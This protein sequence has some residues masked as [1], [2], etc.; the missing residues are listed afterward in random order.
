MARLEFQRLCRPL[1]REAESREIEE[2][3]VK[4][5]AK[6]ADFHD[7]TGLDLEILS[8]DQ[9]TTKSMYRNASASYEIKTGARKEERNRG[10]VWFGEDDIDAR[11][12]RRREDE[13][14]ELA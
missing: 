13:S 8:A 4:R 11:N 9:A 14:F 12:R 6:A 2:P 3:R 5:E 1:A 7:R 10:V